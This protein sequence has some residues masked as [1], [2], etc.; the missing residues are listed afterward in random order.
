MG[1]NVQMGVN[2]RLFDADFLNGI[3]L[4]FPDGANWIGTGPFDTVNQVWLSEKVTGSNPIF[5]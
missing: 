3:E 4:R 1:A 5:I 2:M